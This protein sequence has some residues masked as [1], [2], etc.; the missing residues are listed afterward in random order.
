MNR[1]EIFIMITTIENLLTRAAHSWRARAIVHNMPSTEYSVLRS[2]PGT[3][4]HIG[5]C[6]LTRQ[7][8]YTIDETEAISGVQ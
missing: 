6:R 1:L 4:E 3:P 7:S 5:T 8:K 2:A